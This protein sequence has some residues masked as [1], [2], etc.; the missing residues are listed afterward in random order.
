MTMSKQ[1][2]DIEELKKLLDNSNFTLDNLKSILTNN[3]NP[4]WFDSR[5]TIPILKRIMKNYEELDIDDVAEMYLNSNFFDEYYEVKNNK[6][7][8]AKYISLIEYW[9]YVHY[10]GIF[11]VEPNTEKK[12]LKESKQ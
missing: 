9:K 12:G 4:L 3:Q 2:L 6:E 1:D 5:L 8:I 7:T 11:V 10:V